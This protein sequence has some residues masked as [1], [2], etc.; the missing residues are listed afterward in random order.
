MLCRCFSYGISSK[1]DFKSLD[2]ATGSLELSSAQMDR[3]RRSGQLGS[4]FRQCLCPAVTKYWRLGRRDGSAGKGTF[5]QDRGS[6]FDLQRPRGG[7][8]ERT[9]LICPLAS[10]HMVNHSV[11]VRVCVCV[12]TRIPGKKVVQ[13]EGT[14]VYSECNWSVEQN[15][16]NQPF[17]SKHGDSLEGLRST[18]LVE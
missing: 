1:E 13:G 10:T 3:F 14:F 5:P 15:N 11:W 4:L 2:L 16:M 6:S 12:Y 9:L 7:R 18:V 8:N 17:A